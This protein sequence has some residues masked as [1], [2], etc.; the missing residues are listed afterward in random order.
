MGDLM[1]KIQED[2]DEYKRLCK[3]NNE[4]VQYDYDYYG[5]LIVDCYGEHAKKLKRGK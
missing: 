1:K 2:I 4:D 3:D 5:N